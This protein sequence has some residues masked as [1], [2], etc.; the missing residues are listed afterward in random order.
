[1]AFLALTK[2]S[3]KAN[4]E[5][6]SSGSNFLHK[7]GERQVLNDKINHRL[8]AGVEQVEG[9]ME[10]MLNIIKD[11]EATVEKQAVFLQKSIAVV[12]ESAAF[13][14]QV[15][16]STSEAG[17]ISSH[18]LDTAQKGKVAVDATIHHMYDLKGSVEN[19]QRVVLELGN[20]SKKIETIV[21]TIKEIAEQTNLLALNAAIEAARA[22]EHG[23][24]FAVVADEVKKLAERSAR[25]TEEIGGII[26]EINQ[27]TL[28]SIQA[29]E[30]SAE[31][32]HKGVEIAKETEVAID[33]IVI[34]VDQS[35]QVTG[36]INAAS[37]EQAQNIEFLIKTIRDME[38]A[39][40]QV[41]TLAE[42]ATMDTQFQTASMK[43]LH[44]LTKKSD[45]IARGNNQ[46]FAEALAS[47]NSQAVQSKAMQ[48]KTSQAPTLV[49]EERS[50]LRILNNGK[51]R[52]LDPTLSN[53]HAGVNLFI[54]IHSGLVRFG[55]ESELL[56]AVARSWHLEDDGVTWS[57]ILRKGVKFSNG[58]EV[59]A[60][61]F[62]YTIERILSP[63][64][65]SP[66]VWLFD[67]ILG[68]R[69]YIAGTAREVRGI[70]VQDNHRL[71]ITLEKPYNTFLLNLAQSASSIVAHEN[72]VNGK[73]NGLPI[74]AGPYRLRE[75]ADTSCI[76]EA[77]PNYYEGQPFVDEIEILFSKENARDAFANG[78]IDIMNVGKD[79][80]AF[81]Q[82]QPLYK[83]R[84]RIEDGYGTYYAGFNLASTNPLVKSKPARQALNYAVNNEELV[85]TN[86]GDLALPS[87][88]PLPPSI[89]HDR[90]LQGYNY[91]PAKARQLLEEAGFK[92]TQKGTIT[93]HVMGKGF[94]RIADLMQKYLKDVGV[95]LK[96]VQV[97]PD[98]YLS[99]EM[100]RKCD[101]Y[102]YGWVGDSGDPGNFLQPLFYSNIASNFSKYYNPEVER[103]LDI[104]G[105][106]KNPEKRT[107][108]YCKIQQM[109]V[110]DAPWIFLYHTTNNYIC[111]PYIKGAKMHPIGF[112]KFNDIWIDK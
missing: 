77:S 37:H 9:T 55:E 79:A 100:F 15:A 3:L 47:A 81:F 33:E 28:Q 89:L 31:A 32:V 46:I 24:G 29:M 90:H 44:L 63:K 107:E 21:H 27:T 5:V 72:Y 84:A 86:S 104:A 76:L 111:Q 101:M 41:L 17:K 20:K 97:E 110:D 109:I 68:A 14:Q 73:L 75:V 38:M 25:S 53:D 54:N 95:E 94:M 83:N 19:I 64:T 1:M 11:I 40:A 22:G 96:V 52:T 39:A 65:G 102:V 106:I 112:Y 51:P 67:M 62:K 71:A 85:K 2:K 16:V 80:Y 18:A 92:G 36:N 70:K 43:H 69:E 103:L 60:A 108:Q 49:T 74:G 57:F 23:R 45:E 34:A 91:N 26:D 4:D 35:N 61:D 12:N 82:E 8:L 93:I 7:L 99:A 87:K 48:T 78:E 42:N 66:N 88:G 59:T 50:R 105:N 56:P 98:Q 58:R 6:A 30:V 10:Q 13:S